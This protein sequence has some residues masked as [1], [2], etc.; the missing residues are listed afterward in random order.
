M[1]IANNLEEFFKYPRQT[2]NL[3]AIPTGSIVDIGGGGEGIIAQIGKK[4]VTAIEK[5]QSEIDEAKPHAPEAT[6]ILADATNLDFPDSHFDNATA[7]FSGMYMTEPVLQ[8]VFQEV[9]RLLPN[10]GEFWIWD[11]V[12]SYE[13]GPF[14]IPIRVITSTS[15]E[16]ETA[17]GKRRVTTDRTI[18]QVSSFLVNCGFKVK[19]ITTN[20]FWYFMKAVKP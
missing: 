6:W 19:V 2:L 15:N 8:R 10:D 12:I 4:N 20:Q 7:F 16:I 18:D 3:Q 14:I 13:V 9:F 11:A 1:K 5:L 17:Y